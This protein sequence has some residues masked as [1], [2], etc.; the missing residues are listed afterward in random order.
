MTN[1]S[2]LLSSLI[3]RVVILTTTKVS[4]WECD[5]SQFTTNGADDGCIATITNGILA[6]SGFDDVP[7]QWNSNI[8]AGHSQIWVRLMVRPIAGSPQNCNFG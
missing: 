7:I 3:I 1:V 5:D 6:I 8:F 2:L 4:G